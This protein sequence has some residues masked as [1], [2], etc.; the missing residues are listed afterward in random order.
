MIV[1]AATTDRQWHS[2]D[3]QKN[4]QL[5]D[6]TD[7]T[8]SAGTGV[9]LASASRELAPLQTSETNALEIMSILF[10]TSD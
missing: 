9:R 6:C 8:P 7:T 5:M 3:I 10:F 2:E 1:I 4:S